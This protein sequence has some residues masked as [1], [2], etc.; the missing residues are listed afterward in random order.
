MKEHLKVIMVIERYFPIWGGAE[1]QLRQ[2][3]P[4]LTRLGIDV[5]IVTRRWDASMARTDLIDSVPVR[6]LGVPGKQR[7]ATAL[8]AMHTFLYLFR[9]ADRKTV[10]H[11]HGAA[12][13]G[14]LVNVATKPKRA[15]TLVKIATAGRITKLA[16]SFFGKLVLRA[17]KECDRVVCLSD[18]I[19]TELEVIGIDDPKVLRITNGVD[20]DRF[21]PGE[22]RER[23]NWRRSQGLDDA[24]T[25]VVFSGRLVRRKGVDHLLAAWSIV[26]KHHPEARLIILGSGINQPDSVEDELRNFVSDHK[27]YSVTFLGEHE[28]P[29]EV[30]RVSD[31][32]VFPSLKEGFPNALLEA[33]ASGLA[34]VVTDIGGNRDLVTHKK[35]GIL[36][37]IN[38]SDQ[39]VDNLR[40][41]LQEREYMKELG[42]SAREC[43]VQE[44]SIDR[45]AELLF[46]TYHCVLLESSALN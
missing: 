5:E 3:L 45:A 30:L 15:K 46:V 23:K 2:L 7:L 31:I 40:S 12:A 39:L 36:F 22:A 29:W 24:I 1:N 20:C 34:P 8:F 33:M 44:H 6:R 16:N 14:A 19:A 10:F 35:T 4:R 9:I 26:E 41:L 27:L 17:F 37:P 13:L 43:V 38:D 42:R 32:F 25:L 21:R 28:A 18:E 11:S